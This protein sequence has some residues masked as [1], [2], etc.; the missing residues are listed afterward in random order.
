MLLVLAAVVVGDLGLRLD[1]A[2]DVSGPAT[3][4]HDAGALDAGAALGLAPLHLPPLRLRVHELRLALLVAMPMAVA[5]AAMATPLA[6]QLTVV[7]GAATAAVVSVT[8]ARARVARALALDAGGAA[9]EAAEKLAAPGARR[10]HGARAVAR[11]QP[12]RL[13][14]RRRPRAARG[15]GPRRHRRDA[16]RGAVQ[17]VHRG[18]HVLVVDWRWRWWLLHLGGVLSALHDAP[19]VASARSARE[20]RRT[21]QA[22][23]GIS[24][25]LLFRPAAGTVMRKAY[26]KITFVLKRMIQTV[27]RVYNILYSSLS[28]TPVKS[29]RE[30]YAYR[31]NSEG[32]LYTF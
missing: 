6:R 2:V 30:E 10:A 24:L 17:A 8:L 20:L 7:V 15:V 1:A 19:L 23:L 12:P 5:V 14:P 4:R 27:I 32:R 28:Y 31:A 3:G 29:R 22:K 26:R 18:W 9:R 25:S 13:R 16:A 21:P 11:V